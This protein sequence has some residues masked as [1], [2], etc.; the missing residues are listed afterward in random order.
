MRR[1]ASPALDKT[2]EGRGSASGGG[3]KVELLLKEDL[4]QNSG[5]L[6]A[7]VRIRVHL[8]SPSTCW[9]GERDLRGK[10]ST[11]VGQDG[12]RVGWGGRGSRPVA[13]Y[14]VSRCFC[15]LRHEY[16]LHCR[17]LKH[18]VCVGGKRSST[19]VKQG[20]GRVGRGGDAVVPLLK[21]D[22]YQ[23]SGCLHAVCGGRGEQHLRRTRRW[24]CHD[25][26]LAADN[27]RI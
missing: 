18:D 15:M 25:A 26:A 2:G 11:C 17:A 3:G 27:D 14:Q 21:G 12:S 20:G 22:L 6:Y 5:C 4:Y 16:V 24:R 23:V 10:C 1:E 8:L 13:A 9:C 7:V 19:C